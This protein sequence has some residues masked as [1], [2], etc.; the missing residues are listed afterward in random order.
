MKAY[1]QDSVRAYVE[2]DELLARGADK[3]RTAYA[4]HRLQQSRHPAVI[5]LCERSLA[6]YS[7]RNL[8]VK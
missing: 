7:A 6:Q 2:L 8:F 1:Y 5:W 4:Y 3:S